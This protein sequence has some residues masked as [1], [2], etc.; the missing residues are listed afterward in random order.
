MAIWSFLRMAKIG[1][2]AFFGHFDH[3]QKRTIGHKY[4]SFGYLS[5]EHG[6]TSPL[7]LTNA[8]LV[9]RL[10]FNGRSKIW[11][12]FVVLILPFPMQILKQLAERE[13]CILNSETFF[14][15]CIHTTTTCISWTEKNSKISKIQ[16]TL[17]YNSF[18]IRILSRLSILSSFFC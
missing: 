7:D 14:L 4:Q 8:H 17:M 6:K 3:T 13:F 16:N 18:S 2:S 9:Y 12:F 11:Q 1:I 10:R 5:K 15:S